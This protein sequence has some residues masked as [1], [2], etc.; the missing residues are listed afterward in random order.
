MDLKKISFCDKESYNVNSNDY[1]KYILERIKYEKLL[2]IIGFNSY[3]NQYKRNVVGEDYFITTVTRGN[4]YLLLLFRDNLNRCVCLLIDCKVCKGYTYPR[5]NFINY[6]FDEKLYSNT[7]FSC[8]LLKFGS[9]W[10]LLITDILMYCN[11][12]LQYSMFLTRLEKI[13]NIMKHEYIQ[14]DAIEICNLRVKK[15]YYKD[16]ILECESKFGFYF[17]PNNPNLPRIQYRF[18]SSTSKPR[19]EAPKISAPM[20]KQPI[21]TE[22]LVKM[23]IN[24]KMTFKIEFGHMPGI[25]YL[26]ARNNSD[27]KRVGVARIIGLKSNKMIEQLFKDNCLEK[28]VL[29]EFNTRFKKWVPLSVSGKSVCS[30]S[31][32]NL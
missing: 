12:N 32:I 23:D 7:I 20:A 31:E 16:K 4:P 15:Y 28:K 24:S 14:D 11:K 27:F 6:R 13:Y 18:K 30:I 19:L 8:E 2:K 5:I 17:V 10:T 9:Q 1:K 26:S 29:C 22:P 3:K 21:K 25:Y